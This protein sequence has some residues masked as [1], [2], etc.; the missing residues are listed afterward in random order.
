MVWAV[1]NEAFM[2]VSA[3]AVATGWYWIRRRQVAR[4]RR[5]MLTGAA[6]AVAFFLTYVGKTLFVGDT[7]FG[8][9]ARLAGVYQAFLQT[10]TILATVA[11]VLGIVTLR[12]AFRRE[13]RRHRRIAPW[14]ATTWLVT[15]AT[16]L[17]VFLLLYVVFPPGPTS[18][19]LLKVLFG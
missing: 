2:I 12:R 5:W 1:L 3:V 6:C 4:H 19:N 7:A 14:T 18:T 16:G 10:H 15:A 8:G 17:G 13:F 9:P 11:A